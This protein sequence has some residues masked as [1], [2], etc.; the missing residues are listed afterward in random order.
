MRKHIIVTLAVFFIISML[1]G[2]EAPDNADSDG[3]RNSTPSEKNSAQIITPQPPEQT[4]STTTLPRSPLVAPIIAEQHIHSEPHIADGED[5]PTHEKT[6][7]FSGFA[8]DENGRYDDIVEATYILS[9]FYYEGKLYSDE[10]VQSQV[11]LNIKLSSGEEY[12]CQYDGSWY[13]TVFGADLYSD[14]TD[15]LVV[16]LLNTTSTYSSSQVHVL[17]IIANELIEVLT[18]LD[19]SE[20]YDQSCLE[21]NNDSLY[22]IPE[23]DDHFG[24]SYG[25]HANRCTGVESVDIIVDNVSY[26]ALKIS[27]AVR[28]QFPYSILYYNGVQWEVAE[29]YHT[30]MYE[31]EIVDRICEDMPEYHFIAR[32]ET[33]VGPLRDYEWSYAFVKVLYVNDENNHTIFWISFEDIPNQVKGNAIYRHMLDTMGL[34]V[35]DVNFDGYKDVI[36]LNTFAGAHSNTWYDCWLWDAETSSFTASD[37]FS[38][39]CNPALDFD[40]K[41]I[42]SAGGSGAAY[43]GGRI[44]RFINGEFVLTNDLDTDLYGLEETELVDG[45]M[46]VIREVQYWENEQVISDEQEYYKNHELWQLSNPRWYWSGGHH[47]DQWL[48]G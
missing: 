33:N 28:D 10:S 4:A 16:W 2:C 12:T 11:I 45:E 6:L 29:Q 40:N 47:A 7:T 20:E 21:R 41:C 34:H 8:L 1:S 43:W 19:G 9:S 13:P 48:G 15:A 31:Y 36:I 39:I 27:H 26:Y 17:K 18:V 35:V 30:V 42:Y 5:E 3:S 32:G 24:L 44:Y 23:P 37:S 38:K 22:I 25:D 14:G 46:V